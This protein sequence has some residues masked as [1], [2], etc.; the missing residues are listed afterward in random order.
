M[1]RFRRIKGVVGLA[2]QV[3]LRLYLFDVMY[4][5]GENL[6]QFPYVQRRQILSETAGKIPLTIQL[7]TGNQEEAERFLEA[8]MAAGHEGLMAKKL[9]S[10]YTPGTRGKRWFKIKQVLE[11]LDLVITAAEYGYGRRHNWLS[12]YY[13]SARDEVTGEFITLGKTFKGLTD[14]ELTDMTKRLK[15]LAVR[16][17]GNKVIVLPKIVVEVAYNEIQKSSRYKSEMAL[18]FARITRIRDDKAPEDAD[19]LQRVKA[20]YEKQF[21]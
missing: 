7:V 19:T 14:A 6:I 5:N 18:R 13:L 15:A 20:I 9:E 3:P 1:R 8:A 17:E 21:A 10:P 2:E 4:L 16:Q 11:S 12:D